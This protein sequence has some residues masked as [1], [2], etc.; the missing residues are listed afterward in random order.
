M[1][2]HAAVRW[3]CVV[4]WCFDDGRTSGAQILLAQVGERGTVAPQRRPLGVLNGLMMAERR[5][6][7]DAG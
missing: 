4:G 7:F 6:R 1:A 2:T 3:R 5:Q